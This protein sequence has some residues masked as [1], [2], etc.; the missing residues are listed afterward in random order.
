[1]SDSAPITHSNLRDL[2]PADWT[3]GMVL[4]GLGL[5]LI[6]IGVAL[7]SLEVECQ[8]D[9]SEKAGMLLTLGL[10][11]LVIGTGRPTLEA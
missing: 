3:D 6:C 10:V 9:A 1:M 4:Q 11:F 7:T 8:V 2:F 5:S